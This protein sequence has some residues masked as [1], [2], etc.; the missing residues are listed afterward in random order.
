MEPNRLSRDELEYELS[1]R[2]IPNT[3]ILNIPIMR[4]ELTKRLKKETLGDIEDQSNVHRGPAEEIAICTDKLKTLAKMLSE[5]TENTFS[6]EYRKITSKLLH[7]SGRL[8]RID[9]D[10]VEIKGS[11]KQLELQMAIFEESLIEM[12]DANEL[13]KEASSTP[14]TS[15]PAS[16]S[17]DTS[18][19]RT[20]I[21]VSKW[22]LSF[23]G[24]NNNLSV[25][26]F[27]E[28][29]EE[30]SIARNVSKSELCNS[31]VELL[32][33]RALVWYRSIKSKIH[34][35]DEF[36]LLLRQEY[37]PHDYEI[38]LWDEIRNRTQ[39]PDETVGTYFACMVN[40]FSRLPTVV[41]EAQ[42]L[43][44]LR[45]NIAPYYI[46]AVGLTPINSV[47]ELRSVCKQL[48]TN[49]LMAEKFQPPPVNRRNLLEPDLSYQGRSRTSNVN[50]SEIRT[51]RNDTRTDARCWNCN[52]PDHRHRDC[53][54][55]RKRF[56]YGCG[57]DNQTKTTCPRCQRRVSEN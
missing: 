7:I 2:G 32:K 56:C 11:I 42:R 18:I 41:S 14:P 35:W 44:V 43:Q 53:T 50:V 46:R 37:E 10:D 8:A 27:L 4:Q 20:Q 45:R 57:L 52:S 34:S 22:D 26:A 16:T 48:E 21:P 28:R 39:G 1:V 49:R 33:D 29:V 19:N 12:F 23:N 9:S 47:D 30:Y 3:R 31:V 15:A 54:R 36:V 17:T 6:L 5:V 24:D 25:N 13:K 55:A 40:L 51:S 38:E